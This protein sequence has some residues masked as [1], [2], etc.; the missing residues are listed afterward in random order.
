MSVPLPLPALPLAADQLAA[1]ERALVGLESTALWWVSGYAAGLAAAQRAP[2]LR[3]VPTPAPAATLIYGTQTGNSRHLAEKLREALEAAGLATRVFRAGE[4]PQRELANEKLLFVVIST[5]GD[6]DPPDDAR[7]LLEFLDSRKAPKLP[8]LAYAVLALG[9]SSYPHYCAV[10]KRV[11]ARLAALGAQRIE[12]VAELDLDFDAA[13]AAWRERV[14]PLARERAPA[15]ANAVTANVTALRPSVAPR[16][17]GRERP[18]AAEV[19]ANQRITARE[20]AKDVRHVELALADSGPTYEPGDALAVLPRNPEWLVAR[21]VET[22]GLDGDT[23]V[24]RGDRT[25]SLAAWLTQSLEIT[26]LS[27]G[28]LAKHAAVAEDA[29][30]NRLLAPANAPALSERLKSW[31]LI[32]LLQRHPAAWSA[33]ELV[34]ALPKLTARQYSIA[35]SAKAVGDEVHLT[36]AV[37]DL[38]VDGE[39]R[40]GAASRYLAD[41]AE[42]AKLDVYVES[43]PRF[44]LPADASRDVLMIGPGTGVAPFRAFVQER[45]AVGAGG[46]NWLLFGNGHFRSEFLYQLEWQDA[47]KRGTL[48]RLDVAWS[49]DAAKKVYVQQRLREAGR[50]VYAWLE[51]GAHVY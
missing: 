18:F 15:A 23:V 36:V 51:S 42:G 13:A 25:Q 19:L 20:S 8:E 33:N 24:A 26:R 35:S 7:A 1:V 47:L 49:R 9:D 29:E 41:A 22:L 2:A 28:V 11:D 12:G 6:G 16:T 40:V 44:R 43:N 34:A 17:Y 4:Y 27:R 46:R 14:V 30:L 48:D 45:A 5:Q 37:R 3:A 21:I 39:R 32:D 38:L 50:D 31:Q 10:G